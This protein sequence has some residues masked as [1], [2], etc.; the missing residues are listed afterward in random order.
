MAS[1][2]CLTLGAFLAAAT[3][4]AIE[5]WN[6]PG[7]TVRPVVKCPVI[8]FE[9]DA[10]ATNI[11]DSSSI[12]GTHGGI[13]VESTIPL[14][15]ADY[16]RLI[17]EA[18]SAANKADEDDDY[19]LEER[20]RAEIRT[21]KKARKSLETNKEALAE[22]MKEATI[23]A[24]EAAK[25]KVLNE[26]SLQT[27]EDKYADILITRSTSV[28]LE[29]GGSS[30]NEVELSEY[31]NTTFREQKMDIT[32]YEEELLAGS[33]PAVADASEEANTDPQKFLAAVEKTALDVFVDYDSWEPKQVPEGEYAQ[34]RLRQI[35]SMLL[36]DPNFRKSWLFKMAKNKESPATFTLGPAGSGQ[37]FNQTKGRWLAVVQGSLRVF[38]YHHSTLPPK[39][40][41]QKAS[42]AE[43][44]EHIYPSVQ[45][46]DRAPLEVTLLPGNVLHIPSGFHFASLNCAETLYLTIWDQEE[47]T[48][49]QIME[50]VQ[51][52]LQEIAADIRKTQLEEADK[53]KAEQEQ[54]TSE[55]AQ[56]G[57]L[58]EEQDQAMKETAE[59]GLALLMKIIKRNVS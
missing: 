37:T 55:P 29:N 44:T 52:S 46:T 26:W 22:A 50:K 25:W 31:L 1:K 23:Y 30:W 13:R 48:P 56:L 35:Q 39:T 17:E 16:A 24:H 11:G 53:Y 38:L 7:I 45:G 51:K 12:V 58:T 33:A 28:S 14:R 3:T 2:L 32:E 10:A 8:F 15:K 20:M 59:A 36:K 43:W 6:T 57:D 47:N 40:Y 5:S 41:P 19:E 34:G 18:R 4:S 42:I 49:V 54:D 27:L 9:V 21:L